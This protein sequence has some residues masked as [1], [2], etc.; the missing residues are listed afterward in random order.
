MNMREYLSARRAFSLV[1]QTMPASERLTF[2]EMAMLCHLSNAE[3]PLRTSQIADY[4][5]VLRPT[6]T[7]RTGHLAR[8][9]LIDRIPGEIDRRSVC[10]V[11]TER[12]SEVLDELLVKI[13]ALIKPPAPL[14]RCVPARMCRIL[15]AMGSV[16]MSA[17]DL[18]L[19]GLKGADEAGEGATVGALVDGL[20]LLQ[21]TVSMAVATLV[22]QGLVVR[23]AAADAAHGFKVA[24]SKTG[25]ERAEFL[26]EKIGSLHICTPRRPRSE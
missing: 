20:G 4:Q 10:C 7:H 24:L 14:S 11:L 12:G 22:E 5:G 23:P 18:V 21:P 1:R 19:I 25:R 9:G 3:E 26:T 17:G 8:L 6:M 2:E 13:C 15:D 16:T